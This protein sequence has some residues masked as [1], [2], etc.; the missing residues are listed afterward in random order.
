MAVLAV[1]S[2][3]YENVTIFYKNSQHNTIGLMVKGDVFI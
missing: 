3:V 1:K 2:A